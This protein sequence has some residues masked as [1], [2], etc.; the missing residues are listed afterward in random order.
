MHPPVDIPPRK[1]IARRGAGRLSRGGGRVRPGGAMGKG[2]IARGH[3]PVAGSQLDEKVESTRV[4]EAISDWQSVAGC[5]AHGRGRGFLLT[6]QAP[7]ADQS[8]EQSARQQAC[9]PGSEI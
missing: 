5:I 7:T 3:R 2:Y 4:T 1:G 9:N 6:M 8:V